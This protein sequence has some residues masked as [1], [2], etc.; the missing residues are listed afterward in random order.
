MQ[1]L[2]ICKNLECMRALRY[3]S[4]RFDHGSR[5]TAELQM[6][7]HQLLP[8]NNPKS[9]DIDPRDHEPSDF[10][11]SIA[12][13]ASETRNYTATRKRCY[14]N[15]T[16]KSSCKK[17]HDIVFL[18]LVQMLFIC[19]GQP[20]ATPTLLS[21]RGGLAAAA[22]YYCCY[23]ILLLPLHILL[24]LDSHAMYDVLPSLPCWWLYH[25]LLPF[26]AKNVGLRMIMLMLNMMS[27]ERHS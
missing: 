12:A 5:K 19:H 18:R 20:S 16:G 7:L 26:L 10:Q 14:A 6:R 11:P 2:W 17:G 25:E 15:V 3:T 4:A 1:V 22:F 24:V 21:A 9:R 27:Y 8:L 23:C 13:N